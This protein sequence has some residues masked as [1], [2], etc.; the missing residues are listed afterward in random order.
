MTGLLVSVRGVAEAEI[1][2]AAGVD[3]IDVKEP[4]RGSLGAATFEVIHDV[5]DFIAGEVTVSAAC[6]EL[7]DANGNENAKLAAN[8]LRANL[9]KIGLANCNDI[10]NWQDRWLAWATSLSKRTQPVAVAYA[11]RELA[12]SPRWEDILELAF[13]ANAP[14]LLV[15]TFDKSSGTLFDHWS[16]KN[17][18]SC[19]DRART[20]GIGVVLA[21]SLAGDAITRARDFSPDYLAVRGAACRGGRQ[22]ELDAA[23]ISR[24][25][26][27]LDPTQGIS[28][29]RTSN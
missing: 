23:A 20:A 16:E 5:V 21:G 8:E 29:L 1:A 2:L 7:L 18:K 19:V 28:A 10:P 24:I 9:A 27:L 12:R 26:G 25:R 4:S 17:L 3:I 11:D 13:Q 14:C 15:D 22:G 6:G